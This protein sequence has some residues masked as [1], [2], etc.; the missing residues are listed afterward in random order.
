[1]V[2]NNMNADGIAFKIKTINKYIEKGN[3]E[4]K[5]QFLLV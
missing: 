2:D 3:K 4:K 1:M 5:M